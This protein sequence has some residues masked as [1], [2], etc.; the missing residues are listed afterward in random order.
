MPSYLL[1]RLSC[2]S[3]WCSASCSC[4][5]S[6]L[7]SSR[8][9]KRR[10]KH[11]TFLHE[12][13][14]TVSG[15]CNNFQNRLLYLMYLSIS[16]YDRPML[17]WY[18]LGS[19]FQAVIAVM[20]A[21]ITSIVK[22]SNGRPSAA[23]LRVM[24]F[25]IGFPVQPSRWCCCCKKSD[26]EAAQENALGSARSTRGLLPLVEVATPKGEHSASNTSST[27][28]MTS[29]TPVVHLSNGKEGEENNGWSA[30]ANVLNRYF[31]IAYVIIAIVLF[32]VFLVP[33]FF[34]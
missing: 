12:H 25:Y 2:H 9:L 14:F 13:Y 33:L 23:A 15:F 16:S 30:I 20:F 11:F 8:S 24:V 4:R 32:C 29:E 17:A 21:I 10:T 18:I 5:P 3:L 6:C 1:F 26:N 28:N 7:H 31:A 22:S 27:N 34:L 19:L